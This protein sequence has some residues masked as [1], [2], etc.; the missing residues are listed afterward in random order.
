MS[1]FD[2]KWNM[3]FISHTNVFLFSITEKE[4][5]E[6]SDVSKVEINILCLNS[7]FFNK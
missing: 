3:A 2:I 5:V 4:V 6:D 1:N 7:L